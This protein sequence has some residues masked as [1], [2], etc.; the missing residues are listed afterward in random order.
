MAEVWVD[1]PPLDGVTRVR[2]A[3][4]GEDLL[5][6]S[7]NGRIYIYDGVGGRLRSDLNVN[8]PVLDASFDE[9]GKIFSA[10]LGG[11]VMSHILA[12]DGSIKSDLIGAHD[13]AARC[14]EIT[15]DPKI[16]ATGGWDETLCGW[17]PDSSTSSP[18]KPLFSVKVP[19]RVFAMS[20][21]GGTKVLV[22][23]SNRQILLFDVRN[24][25]QPELQRYSCTAENLPL[26]RLMVF[27]SHKRSI[28]G[29]QTIG[30]WSVA[31]DR[32]SLL[33]NQL[34]CIV[35]LPDG[36]GFT[37]ASTEGRVAI[38]KLDGVGS[39]TFKCHRV[40]NRIY[41]VNA[42]S[43]HPHWHTFATGGAD[44]SVSVWDGNAKKR[45]RHYPR[46]DTSVS[47]L[48]FHPK[49]NL[50]AVA[51][52]YTFEEGDKAHPEDKVLLKP[53][54]DADVQPRIRKS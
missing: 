3:S 15:R 33:K 17:S 27:P 26:Q 47:S 29:P 7:W 18:R 14:L 16:I 40:G 25:S 23:T 52:S 28:R 35:G 34:R 48:A 9:D 21:L 54:T 13:Q 12:P 31:Y 30:F 50:L 36:S 46:Y 1:P 5:V 4:S 41:P 8:A 2:Y 39:Y 38:E 51:I 24:P 37:A 53:V 20:P 45:I 43:F 6:A 10:A 44:G 22:G 11:N 49:G 42:I 19:G 32:E